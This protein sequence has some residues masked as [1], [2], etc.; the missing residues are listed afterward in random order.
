M[1]VNFNSTVETRL[2]FI[3]KIENARLFFDGYGNELNLKFEVNVK[4]CL[5]SMVVL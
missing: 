5:Q 1:V 4:S 2:K 3:H